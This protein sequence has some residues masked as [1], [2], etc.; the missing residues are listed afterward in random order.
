[1]LWLDAHA[2]FNTP[3]T[4]PRGFLGGMCLAAACGLWD[5]RLRRRRRSTRRA[6]VMC[7][8]RDLDGRRARRCSRRAAS[9]ASTARRCWPRRSPAARSSSTSTST[10]ST[11]RSSPAPFPVPG[12]LSDGGLRTLL[13]EV[14]GACDLVGFEIT[15]FHDPALVELIASV[16]EPLVPSATVSSNGCMSLA[17]HGSFLTDR[18][19][20]VGLRLLMTATTNAPPS[21]LRPLVEDL[22]ERRARRPARRRRGADR[23]PARGRQADRARAD[24]AADRR[25]AR[26]PSSGIHAG[27]PLLGAR[28]GGQGRA[29]PTA[30]SPATARS[31]AGWSRSPPTTSR[32]WPARWA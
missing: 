30:S 11:P 14:A 32:S 8:V 16:V 3:E 17:R 27:H 4:T 19:W 26:S 21:L 15:G 31:T 12:G 1:M 9:C 28:A 2:D 29:R 25:R 7:G 20:E 22:L 18:E 10:C 13:A 23:P 6:V 24:R 5:A